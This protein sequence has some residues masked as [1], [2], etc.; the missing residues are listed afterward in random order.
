MKTFDGGR[1][2]MVISLSGLTS[3]D[4]QAV[5]DRAYTQFVE[6]LTAKGITVRDQS[7]FSAALKDKKKGFQSPTNDDGTL[8][9]LPDGHDV[10][11]YFGRKKSEGRALLY[12][13]TALD[14]P[15]ANRDHEGLTLMFRGFKMTKLMPMALQF[16]AVSKSYAKE[17]TVAVINPLIVLDFADFDTYDGKYVRAIEA[18]S[19]LAIAG[20]ESGVH[21]TSVQFYGANGKVGRI[22]LG[23]SIATAG[24]FGKIEK[25]GGVPL[26]KLMGL[27][28]SSKY[29]FTVDK[30]EWERGVQEL[31]DEVSTLLVDALAAR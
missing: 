6:K 29:S 21:Q 28:T 26:G 7:G 11:M 31:V 4:L 9:T 24:A 1:K 5:T 15:I 10:K 8:K 12:T 13:P 30:A 22:I 23:D 27:S 16:E 20:I 18:K 17:N 14:G 2:S 25:G 19:S 3:D